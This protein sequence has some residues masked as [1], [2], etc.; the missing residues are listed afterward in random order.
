MKLRFAIAMRLSV[1]LSASTVF[2]GLPDGVRYDE[3][4]GIRLSAPTARLLIMEARSVTR[5]K[6]ISGYVA[7]LNSTEVAERAWAAFALG[8]FQSDSALKALI[9]RAQV[10]TSASVTN[11]IF[12]QLNGVFQLFGFPALPFAKDL[13]SKTRERR[14]RECIEAYDRYGYMGLFRHG[15]DTAKGRGLEAVQF[16]IAGVT[17]RYD[18]TLTPLLVEIADAPE[19]TVSREQIGN[20]ILCWSGY[21]LERMGLSLLQRELT[22]PDSLAAPSICGRYRTY[23]AGLGYT[24][25][26]DRDIGLAVLSGEVD[27]KHEYRREMA[28]RLIS[29]VP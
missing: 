21:D 27:K 8:N 22:R 9:R 24:G 10:E 20:A 4:K 7:A 18:P 1:C 3:Q 11:E 13:S 29:C 6:Y 23:F 15:W 12:D 5:E 16:F 28:L 26:S 2:A 17:A 19:A 25:S 14:T